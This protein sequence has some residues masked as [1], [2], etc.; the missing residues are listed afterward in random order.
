MNFVVGLPRTLGKF[1]AIWVIM[2]RLTMS[3]HFIPVQATYNPEK[4]AKIYICEIFHLY[5][6]PISIISERETQFT[7]HFLRYMQKEL[8]T[9]VELSTT[10]YSQTKRESEQNIQVLKNML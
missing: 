9:R 3:T 1:G 8:G 10:F 7:S 4:F 2:D 5:G 6:M